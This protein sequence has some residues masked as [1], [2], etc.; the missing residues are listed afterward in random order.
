MTDRYANI[1]ELLPVVGLV[2]V[3]VTQHD[4]EDYMLGGPA[5]FM[6]HFDSGLTLQVEVCDD[7]RVRVVL[8]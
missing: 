4:E 3:E 6:I 8:P 5:F 7:G 1:R 2:V